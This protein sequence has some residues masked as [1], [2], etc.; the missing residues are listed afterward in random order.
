MLRD[1]IGLAGQQRLVHLQR[2]ISD[3]RSVGKNL[4]SGADAQDIAAHDL[5]WFE[6]PLQSVTDDGGLA[7][8]EQGDLVQPT[9]GTRL[10]DDPHQPVDDRQTR[11]E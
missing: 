8:V 3:D 2:A 5:V 4:I 1:Q 11:G 10:L 6:R 9:F 7:A